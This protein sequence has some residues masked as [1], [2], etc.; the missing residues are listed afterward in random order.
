MENK[1]EPIS[2]QIPGK[3]VIGT[4]SWGQNYGA[5]NSSIIEI[6]EINRI[7]VLA[8][9]LGVS[10]LDTAPNYGDSEKLIGDAKVAQYLIYSKV[11]NE[12]WLSGTENAYNEVRGSLNRLRSSFFEGLM[13]HSTEPIFIDAKKAEDFMQDLVSQGVCKKWGV[14]V[15]TVE[16]TE[17]VLEVCKPDFIQLPSNLADRSFAD[18]GMISILKTQGIEVHVRSVFLQGLILQDPNKLPSK[19][20]SF[21][22]WLSNLGKFS[23]ECGMTKTQLALLYN[24]SNPD[25]DKVL[26]GVNSLS[27]FEEAISSIA[28]SLEVPDFNMLSSV[29]NTHLIDPRRW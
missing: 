14:S 16:E 12:S 15:Y 1:L 27:H 3:L 11:S 10:H 18:S 23:D 4:S 19:F 7:L 26:I 5:F 8:E 21:S 13:F 17:Q 22:P 20:E 9:E 28:T 25:V 6:D 2:K 29:T 24:L